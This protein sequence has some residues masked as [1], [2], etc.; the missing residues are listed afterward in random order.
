MPDQEV[1]EGDAAREAINE[2]GRRT[3]ARRH[4]EQRE[5]FE[6]VS[7]EVGVLDESAFADLLERQ[8]DDALAL[9]ADLTGATD[10]RLRHLAR[11]LAGRVMVDVAR[12]GGALRPGLGRLGSSPIDRAEGD[13]DVDRSLD[14]LTTWRRGGPPD[15]DGLHVVHWHRP[16]TSVCLL[17]DRSGSMGGD[18]LATA[19]VAASSVL[20]RVPDA[21]SVVAFAEQSVAVVSQ[22]EYR[23]PDD[24][25]VDL[26]RLRGFG[27][28]NL[29]LAL[30]TAGAQLDRAPAG[31]R[32]TVLLSDCRATTGVDPTGAALR[33]DELVVIA[34]AGDSADAEIFAE[35][36]GARW[37]TVDGPMSVPD[38]FAD[39]LGR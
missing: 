38:A 25:V 31:R 18:R 12:T 11:R 9:L 21:C 10:E 7:P 26:L 17:V 13:I 33:L 28:T 19:A 27:V 36:V 29:D 15:R 37:A 34:P 4:L 14:A 20:F 2:A 23:S 39:V 22:Q 3:T 1:L 24:V 6:E 32:I 35:S 30:R 16:A 8:P 5:H